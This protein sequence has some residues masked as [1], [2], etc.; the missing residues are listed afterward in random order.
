MK[1]ASSSVCR[2]DWRTSYR[3]ATDAAALTLFFGPPL[4]GIVFGIIGDINHFALLAGGHLPWLHATFTD[5]L[6]VVFVWPIA[7]AFAALIVPAAWLAAATASV[8]VAVRVGITGR[9]T[10]TETVVLAVLCSLFACFTFQHDFLSQSLRSSLDFLACSVCAALA[11]R[12]FA[13]RRWVT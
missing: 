13:G 12:Y 10:W 7:A 3:R 6:V 11:L 8:Y 1:P 2:T 5:E 4:G 9:I